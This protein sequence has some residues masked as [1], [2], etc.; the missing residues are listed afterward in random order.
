MEPEHKHDG[1][2]PRWRNF[3]LK[4]ESAG[5][6]AVVAFVGAVAAVVVLVLYLRTLAP[7]IV[8]Y[9]WPELIDSVMR[10]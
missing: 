7:T 9:E 1:N 4:E 2:L 10:H 3:P 5:W 8:Q 6:K